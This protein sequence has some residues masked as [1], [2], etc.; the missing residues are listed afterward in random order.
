MLLKQSALSEVIKSHVGSKNFRKAI[1]KKA[2]KTGDPFYNNLKST[3]SCCKS[4]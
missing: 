3:E 4:E 1:M 2:K